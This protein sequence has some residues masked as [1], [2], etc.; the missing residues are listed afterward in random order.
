MEAFIYQ[1]II[2]ILNE[3][4]DEVVEFEYY[5]NIIAGGESFIHKVDVN[6]SKRKSISIEFEKR[7]KEEPKLSINGHHFY[8][9]DIPLT[10]DE[11][12]YITKIYVTIKEVA[13]KNLFNQLI[14]V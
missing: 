9:Y 11:V 6:S 5:E 4:A 8:G 10:V 12:V 3:C 7:Y 1:E 14:S 2:R 13:L